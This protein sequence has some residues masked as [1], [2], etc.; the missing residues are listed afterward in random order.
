MAVEPITLTITVLEL[1]TALY[2]LAQI[3]REHQDPMS[4]SCGKRVVNIIE[5]LDRHLAQYE[6]IIKSFGGS[7]DFH[8]KYGPVSHDWLDG[9]AKAVLDVVSD[10]NVFAEDVMNK[11]LVSR[12][13]SGDMNDKLDHLLGDAI[14]AQ[15]N[16]MC[17]LTF[18]HMLQITEHT[19]DEKKKLEASE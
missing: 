7:Y 3:I 9:N 15:T 19:L 4:S 14:L 12:V 8:R 13:L 5:Q 6:L 16:L 17:G 11:S 10:M 18:L 2:K 1:G